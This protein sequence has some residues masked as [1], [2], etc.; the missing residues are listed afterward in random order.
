MALIERS[1]APVAP[2]LP[3][4]T[5]PVAELGGDVIVRGMLLS[6]SMALAGLSADLAEIKPGEST[7]QAQRRAGRE[8]VF[9]TLASCVVLADGLPFWTAAEW[10]AFGSKH[11]AVVLDLYKKSRRL[12]GHD[13]ADNAKN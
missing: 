7:E 12:G 5:V 1:A 10:D 11:P 8:I 9:F 4:E 6:E 2:I 13:D 3:K